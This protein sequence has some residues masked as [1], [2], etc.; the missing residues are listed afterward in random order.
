MCFLAEVA[1]LRMLLNKTCWGGRELV[2]LH[3][4]Q[5]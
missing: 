2:E 4:K 3:E 1:V 5:P